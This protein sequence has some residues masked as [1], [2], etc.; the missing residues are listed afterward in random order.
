MAKPVT[1]NNVLKIQLN[2]KTTAEEQ[3]AALLDKLDQ[4][5]K[6]KPQTRTMQKS[7]A[8]AESCLTAVESAINKGEKLVM[9]DSTS[10]DK[11]VADSDVLNDESD[12]SDKATSKTQEKKKSKTS[13]KVSARQSTRK[14]KVKAEEPAE[15][16]PVEE[17]TEEKTELEEGDLLPKGLEIKLQ[18][19]KTINLLDYAKKAHILVIFAYPKASTPGCTRQAKGF[20]DEYNELNGKYKASVLGLSADSVSAQTKFKEKQNL[21]YDLVADTDKKLITLLGC[22]KQPK[23]IIRS[24]FIFVDGILKVKKVKVSPEDSF[25]GALEQVAQLSKK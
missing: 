18:S 13:K 6:Q 23:G 25:N 15:E 21:P 7:K 9:F 2:K 10:E 3:K 17:I 4:F 24:H 19:S 14:T 22:K 1:P 12:E 5:E 11:I 20:R 16:E 8:F